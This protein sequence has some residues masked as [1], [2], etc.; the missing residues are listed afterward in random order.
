M[1][2][3]NGAVSVTF[4]PAQNVDLAFAEY[5][6]KRRRELFFKQCV[7]PSR[8]AADALLSAREHDTGRYCSTLS[9]TAVTKGLKQAS[10]HLQSELVTA[11]QGDDTCRQ[12]VVLTLLESGILHHG[13]QGILIDAYGWILPDNGSCR[14]RSATSEPLRGSTWKEY[15]S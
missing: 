12:V 5:Q 1:C 8:L 7:I 3:M 9:I 10:G 14:R 6:H 11:M 4:P 2:V 15:A 13:F